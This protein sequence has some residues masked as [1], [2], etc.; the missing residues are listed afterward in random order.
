MPGTGT[1]LTNVRVDTGNGHVLFDFS[2]GTEL[3]FTNWAD[4]LSQTQYLDTV[5]QTVQHM[6]VLKSVRNSPDGSNMSN[7]VGG[8]ILSDFSAQLP[9]VCTA[10]ILQQL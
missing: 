2:D 1:T 7:M 10:P 5:A 6:L 4:A 9:I 3:E 8:S